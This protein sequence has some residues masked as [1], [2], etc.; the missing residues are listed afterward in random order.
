[1]HLIHE[2]HPRHELGDSLVDISVHHLHGGG[3]HASPE[4]DSKKTTAAMDDGNG[5]GGSINN[6]G[7]RHDLGGGRESKETGGTRSLLA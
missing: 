7:N 3:G 2:Q 4:T 1:M 6:T 5:D